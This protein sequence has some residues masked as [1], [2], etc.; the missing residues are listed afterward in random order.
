MSKP[1]SASSPASSLTCRDTTYL[2]CDARDRALTGHE[3]A[4]LAGHIQSCPYCKVAAQQFSQLFSQ[5]DELLAR[6]QP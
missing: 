5:L 1:S 6:S 4:L 2:V 3:Q